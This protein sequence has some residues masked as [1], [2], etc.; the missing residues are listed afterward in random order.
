MGQKLDS[1][2]TPK[3][4]RALVPGPGNYK[5]EY[6]KLKLSAPSFGFGTSKRPEIGGNKKMQTPG[7]GAYR[8]PT[9]IAD[10]PAYNMPNRSPESKY[11]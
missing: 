11:V 5:N 6:Q 1:S 4:T 2:L 10:T 7:P 9:K 3:T 8:V